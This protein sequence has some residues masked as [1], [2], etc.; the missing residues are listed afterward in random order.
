[1]QR[2]AP[3]QRVCVITGASSGIGRAAAI[4]LS[5][6][7]WWVV[8]AARRADQLQATLDLCSGA[9]R[10]IACDVADVDQVAA[11]AASVAETE[12]RCDA[13]VNNAGVGARAQFTGPSSLERLREVMQVNFFGT[14]HATAHLLELLAA[15]PAAAI[16]NVSSVAGL[17]GAPGASMYC[18]SKFAV[19]GFSEALAA[20]MAATRVRVV[21]IQPGPVV[22]E[23]WPHARLEA[24][25]YGRFVLVDS[26]AVG[27]AI[28]RAAE[29]RGPAVRTMPRVFA[30]GL[31]LK[32]LA[33]PLYRS[34]LRAGTTRTMAD[35]VAQQP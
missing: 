29:G 25:W 26:G 31:V 22:T 23:G 18:A 6:R 16:V 9:G 11:L 5:R 10:A 2:P 33:P 19:T 34:V 15:A 4:E 3:D 14:A 28:A 20:Q 8:L 1:M 27:R 12:G 32:L 30:L 17:Y 13:L 21:T 24:R 35:E 7:G